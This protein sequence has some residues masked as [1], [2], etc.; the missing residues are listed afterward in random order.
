MITSALPYLGTVLGSRAGNVIVAIGSGPYCDERGKYKHKSW[1]EHA[2]AWPAEADRLATA[3][4]QHAA[5]GDDV[6]ACPYLMHGSKRSQGAAV[7]R[8]IVHADIDG[9]ADIDKVRALGGF[10]VGSGTSG[11]GHV[12]VP[13]DRSVPFNVHRELCRA[14][15]AH[16]GYADAKISDNDLLRPPGTFNHKP[17][18]LGGEPAAVEWLLAPSGALRTPEDLADALGITLP[19][20]LAQDVPR[21]STA[22]V[23]TTAVDIDGLPDWLL[24]SI[25]LITDDRSHDQFRIVGACMD[26]GM[27]LEET[28]WIIAQRPDLAERLAGRTDDDVL[29]CWEKAARERAGRIPGDETPTVAETATVAAPKPALRAEGPHGGQ[30]RFALRLAEA[31]KD[32]LIHVHGIG[33]HWWDG[34]RWREDQHGRAK[35]SVVNV[36]RAALLESFRS[37]GEF[38]E[39]LAKDVHKCESDNAIKGVLGIAAA[40]DVFA[41][42]VA[43]LDPDPYLLNVA[44]GTLDLRTM[45]LRAHDPADRITKITRAAYAP[46]ARGPVWEAFLA[47][48]LPDAEVRGFLQRYAGIGLC[49]RVLEHLLAIGTGTGRNGKGV[50]YESFGHALG[51]YAISGAPDLFMASEGRHPTEEFDLRGA[52][53]VVVSEND[54]NRRL[55]EAKV[56]RLVGGDKIRARRMRQDFVE[57]DPTHTA[58][59]VTNHLPKV[60]EDDPALWARLRV[61][62][63]DVVIPP[64]E[65]DKHLGEKLQLEADAIL[66]WAVAGWQDYQQR[67]M[68][69]PEAVRVATT[70]YHAD[71][72][73]IGRF[74]TDECLTGIAH[75]V[76]FADLWER[77]CIWRRDEGA[78]EVSKTAF[79]VALESRG[80]TNDKFRGRR[81]RRGIGLLSTAEEGA[82]DD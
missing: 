27:S 55:A 70:N 47:R 17:V 5:A 9:P 29:R 50:F 40:L 28:R 59:L 16:L 46:D 35:R 4:A 53:W 23:V 60:S 31:A 77:W 64:D 71:A 63:F 78:A 49:G 52:R 69:D 7:A 81:I 38:A 62:P 32:R 67:G 18:P 11:H 51:D 14:L 34:S 48:V 13:L 68:A 58:M 22:P 33:W 19:S 20:E 82:E 42:T 8:P 57:F 41:V 45:E 15:G 80:F 56:K 30:T 2:F 73:A 25:S 36:L 54:K 37:K 75:W 12:Y 65:Q 74:I 72:D 79:G 26:V 6:Y 1:S 43:D 44:N 66:S 3:I 76:E 39:Q 24:S 21:V 61:I 10:A